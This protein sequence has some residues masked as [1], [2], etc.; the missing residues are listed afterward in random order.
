MGGS[1]T[2][3]RKR[4]IILRVNEDLVEKAP[5]LGISVS[6]P[7]KERLADEVVRQ[8]RDTFQREAELIAETL[9]QVHAR[10][11]SPIDEYL[12]R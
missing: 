3:A 10:H 9:N 7:L 8:R 11:G 6:S 12:T 5:A 1:D 2:D 4:P